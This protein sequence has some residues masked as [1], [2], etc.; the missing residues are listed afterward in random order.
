MA[1]N[2]LT[3]GRSESVARNRATTPLAASRATVATIAL[4]SR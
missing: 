4:A 3:I 1:A 2:S